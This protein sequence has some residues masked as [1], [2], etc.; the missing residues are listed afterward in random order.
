MNNRKALELLIKHACGEKVD[1]D[2][3]QAAVLLAQSWLR[4]D[5][6]VKVEGLTLN[7]K[8]E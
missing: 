8:S 4:Q 1:V 7:L 3:L 5:A 6:T 2:D